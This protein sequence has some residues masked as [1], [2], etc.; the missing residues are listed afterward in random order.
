MT[1]IFLHGGPGFK[2][3]LRPFFNDLNSIFYDQLQGDNVTLEDLIVQLDQIVD[4]TPGSKVLVG[5]SWGGV[6][7]GEYA[8]RFENK[9]SGLVIMSTGLNF[10]HWNDEFKEEKKR[11]GLENAAPED[12]FLTSTE[13]AVGRPFMDETWVGFSGETFDSLYESY[14]KT[15]DLTEKLQKLKLPIL[16]IYGDKDVR[17]PVRVAESIKSILVN[18]TE[19]KIENA[20][21]F[22]FLKEENRKKI[23][24]GLTAFHR[25]S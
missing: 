7:A 23:K 14:I 1:F 3:Y 16:F 13:L 11:L 15:F 25:H 19:L 6:L 9:L 21:H 17:F 22:P 8:S 20:G 4:L 12:I 5:H 10:K 24:S 2:D 18:I